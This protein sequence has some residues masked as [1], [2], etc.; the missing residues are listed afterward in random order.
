M[1]RH[2]FLAGLEKMFTMRM[3]A[4]KKNMTN[5]NTIAIQ[6]ASP[7]PEEYYRILLQY[8]FHF[9]TAFSMIS[10][11]MYSSRATS[12]SSFPLTSIP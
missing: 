3:N 6:G 10:Q 9:S 2:I 5:K 12:F 4:N 11:W 8:F 1:E 7:P